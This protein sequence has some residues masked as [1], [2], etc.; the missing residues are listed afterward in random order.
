[1]KL[2]AYVPDGLWAKVQAR[3]PG[4]RPSPVTQL[5]LRRMVERSG[6]RF[7]VE[8]DMESADPLEMRRRRARISAL[9]QR[10]YEEGYEAGLALCDTLLWADLERL[11]A[12]GWT[13]DEDLPQSDPRLASVAHQAGMRDALRDVWLAVVQ[14]ATPV[15][16]V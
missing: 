16:Q 14:V 9:R 1:M 2:S 7:V 8:A 3:F 4:A 11:A 13:L 12:S 10:A 15:E 6:P 5:A